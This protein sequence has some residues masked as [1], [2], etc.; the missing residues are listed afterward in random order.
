LSPGEALA[1]GLAVMVER[2][3]V[4]P[5]TRGGLRETARAREVAVAVD[6]PVLAAEVEAAAAP[7][8]GGERVAGHQQQEA[9]WIERVGIDQVNHVPRPL[10]GAPEPP[11]PSL[12]ELERQR[13]RQAP[14]PFVVARAAD[15]DRQ[16]A[17]QLALLDLAVGAHARAVATEHPARHRQRALAQR[18]AGRSVARAVDEQRAH[19][20][21]E[22]RFHLLAGVARGFEIE[23]RERRGQHQQRRGNEHAR[24]AHQ[25]GKT[26]A[27]LK[28]K[29]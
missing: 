1:L 21:A 16:P 17:P 22:R 11:E 20:L 24:E 10:V 26:L 19:L 14:A 3:I 27:T 15:Q 9:A 12:G 18:Q 13:R 7:L 5:E 2:G 29:V 23:R 4:A 25:R 28:R 8:Q 6:A